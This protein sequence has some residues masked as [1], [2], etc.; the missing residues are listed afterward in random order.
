M[1]SEAHARS[2]R[3]P[4]TKRLRVVAAVI[5]FVVGSGLL[6]K[7]PA[8]TA[9][10]VSYTLDNFEYSSMRIVQPNTGDA[11]KYLWNLWGG[12]GTGPTTL[13]T[14][15]KHS[16][17]QSLRSE[18]QAGN[19]WQFQFYTYTE[20]L[21]GFN[22]GWQFMRKFV[23]N[24]GS[25]QTGKINRMRFWILLPP[26][27]DT[28]NGGNHNFEFGTY[29]RCSTCTE[30]E[31][32]GGHF[33]HHYDLSYTGA[34]HQMIVDPHPNHSRGGSGGTE[35][36]ELLY[37]TNEPGFTYFDLMTRF[38]LDFPYEQFPMPAVFYIDDFELYEEQRP[39]N[40]DQVYS[41]NAV[42]VP[43]SNTVR[44]SWMR[45]KDQDSVKHEV[46]YSFSDIHSI[47]WNAATPAPNGTITP[48]GTAGYNGMDWSSSALPLAGKSLLYIAVKPQNSNLIRQISIPLVAGGSTAPPPPAA[49]TNVR[50]I[51]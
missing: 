40:V 4:R 10:P 41:I 18:F 38:Y 21:A 39:E 25:W 1:F 37:P 13:T 31:D 11:N 12:A 45:R 20:F 9:A 15:Q 26:G 14:A 35:W 29:I 22:N 3:P 46:R 16:G 6:M 51:R 36:G 48:P 43:N 27:T 44:V 49:P 8:E 47:G 19:N 24:P 23:T 17:N 33:Y 42:H 50:V 7:S 32:G 28:A 30:A 2:T 5:V 34:W